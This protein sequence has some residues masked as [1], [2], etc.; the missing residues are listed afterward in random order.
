MKT[1]IDE[2]ERL[3]QIGNLNEAESLWSF[4]YQKA[5]RDT[6][7]ELSLLKARLCWKQQL[8]GES[9]NWYSRVLEIVPDHKEATSGIEMAGNILGFLNPEQFNP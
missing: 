9:I 8:W 6:T 4:V 5:G 1:K 3:I 2:I 7:G